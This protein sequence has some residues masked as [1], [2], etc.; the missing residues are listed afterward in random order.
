MMKLNDGYTM[1]HEHM[2]IDLSGVKNDQDCCLDCFDEICA[3]LKQL[4]THGVRNIWEVTNVGMGRDIDTILKLEKASGIHFMIS[5]GCYKDP[6]IPDAMSNLTVEELADFMIKEIVEGIDGSEIKADAIGEVGTSK[7]EWTENERRLFEAALIAH[8]ATNK[9]IYT[10]TTLATLA[11]EQATYLIEH[12]A[13]PNKVVIGHVDLS[14]DLDYIRSILATGVTVGFDTIGKNNYLSDEKRIEFLLALEQEGYL[15]QV[16]LSEDLTRKSHL[17]AKGGIG[18]CYLFE[19]FIPK[20]MKA[21][22]SK[23]SLDQMLIH[24]PKRIFEGCYD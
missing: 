7:N 6:F 10:H 21:G 20:L 14:G 16:V 5:T 13:N 8:E 17:K 22:L 9:P 24:N 11:K 15:N 2:H 1:M 19:S 12:G 4:Y 3:E 18:Y 23:A